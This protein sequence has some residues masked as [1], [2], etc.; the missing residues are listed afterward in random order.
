MHMQ[1][2]VAFILHALIFVVGLYY[3]NLFEFENEMIRLETLQCKRLKTEQY[4]VGFKAR[5]RNNLP[6]FQSF[7][8]S[9]HFQMFTLKALKPS[10]NRA[11]FKFQV[12]F[13][14]DVSYEKCFTVNKG[15]QRHDIVPFSFE[16]SIV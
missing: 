5:Q 11:I 15:P 6:P 12:V 9:F 13:S 1:G 16:N 4:L 14:F 7:T 8:K 3:T 2:V 10:S